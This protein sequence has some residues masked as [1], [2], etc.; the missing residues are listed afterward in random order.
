MTRNGDRAALAHARA[1]LA[2]RGSTRTAGG[3]AMR[4]YLVLFIVLIVVIPL[5]RALVVALSAPWP[6]AILTA[7]ATPVAAVIGATAVVLVAACVGATRGAIV[8][9]PA[10]VH[11]V[12][13]S[14]LPGSITLGRSLAAMHILA[15]VAFAIVTAIVCGALAIAGHAQNPLATTVCI[16]AAAAY[17]ML[18]VTAWLA[19][20]VSAAVRT[21]AGIALGAVALASAAATVSGVS[22]DAAELAQAAVDAIKVGGVTPIASW[23]IVSIMIA[24][25]GVVWSRILL[26]RLRSSDLMT[27]GQIWASAGVMARTGDVRGSLERV[28]TP[29]RHTPRRVSLRRGPVWWLIAKRDAAGAIRHPV[30]LGLGVC[31]ALLAGVLVAIASSTCSSPACSGTSPLSGIGLFIG[32]CAGMLGYLSAGAFSDGVRAHADNIGAPPLFGIAAQPLALFHLILPLIASCVLM[33]AGA[34]GASG[35]VH[36]ELQISVVTASAFAVVMV[37]LRGV[38][39]VKGPLPITLLLPV[40]TPVGDVSILFALAWAFDGLLIA[41]GIGMCLALGVAT[42]VSSPVVYAALLLIALATLGRLRL[43]RL[44]A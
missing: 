38:S 40:P 19:G 25:A 35:F 7:E 5:I 15:A 6:V 27:Q 12:V 28:R 29:A 24:C 9:R 23:L 11:F 43:Q 2:G 3:M 22:G 10:Y 1:V 33:V 21:G 39:A 14:P 30:R 20:Q 41:L 31:C 44:S 42:S 18:L 16:V 26:G 13:R 32:A 8:P 34:V 36:S 17:A 37:A 4:A